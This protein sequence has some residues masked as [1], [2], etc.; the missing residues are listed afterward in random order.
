MRTTIRLPDELLREAKKAA[1]DSGMSL[2]QLIEEAVRTMLTRRLET[3]DR[4]RVRLVTFS[5]EGVQPGV[6]LDDSAALLDRM[7]PPD[8]ETGR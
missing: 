7:D 4:P 3:K 8:R 2:T 5:G 6:D 1:A